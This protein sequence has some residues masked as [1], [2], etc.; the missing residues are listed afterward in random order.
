MIW[1]WASVCCGPRS[2]GIYLLESVSPGFLCRYHLSLHIHK[3]L[4]RFSS[5]PLS[6]PPLPPPPPPPSLAHAISELCSKTG[7]LRQQEMGTRDNRT[8]GKV[9]SP[10]KHFLRT[11]HLLSLHVKSIKIPELAVLQEPLESPA[12]VVT[13]RAGVRIKTCFLVFEILCP[14]KM[15]TAA[16]WLA[17]ASLLLRSS[18]GCYQC[19]VDVE[20]SL[21]LCWGHVLT[22]YNVRNVDECFRKLDRIFNTNE[23]VIEAGRVGEGYDKNLKEILEAEI[24]PLVEEF[25]QKLNNESVYETRLQT[26]ADN[27]IAAASKL[28]RVSGCFPPCGFQILGAVYNCITCQYDSCEFP[29]DCPVEDIEVMENSRSRM[30]CEV[31]FDLPADIEVIWRFAEEVKT[32]EMDQFKEVTVGVDRLYSIPSTS[33]QHQGTYQCEIYSGGRSIV[34]LY[35]YISVTSQLVVGHT[36]LQE[37]FDLS[38]LPGG[39]LLPAPDASPRSV[40]LLLPFLLATCLT[41]SLL[42][43]F[44]S[45]GALHWMS[46]QTRPDED[47]DE[48]EDWGLEV[49]NGEESIR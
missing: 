2:S 42:L 4:T 30:W 8:E 3:H 16:L 36:E 22:E 38:L 34:R 49:C 45:L 11:R 29:L 6:P 13:M 37:I 27:F 12:P 1:P 44:V 33:L 46:G 43:L 7:A 40:V 39:Q 5:A 48:E 20:D 19:F 10:L 26:A 9:F 21:R 47:S 18:L 35:Y 15:C 32:Q 17:C 24:L 31:P 25:D 28:P 14:V 23:T 41:T